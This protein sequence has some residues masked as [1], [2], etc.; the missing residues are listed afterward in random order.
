MHV[1]GVIA[2]AEQQHG[3]V[4]KRQAYTMLL[5]FAANNG[6]NTATRPPPTSSPA[7][8]AGWMQKNHPEQ[9]QAYNAFC[10]SNR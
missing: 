3:D 5:Q 2:L 8:V 10:T 6:I 1:L 9:V 7:E 4:Y